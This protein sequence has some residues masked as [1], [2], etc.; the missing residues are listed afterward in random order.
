[1]FLNLTSTLWEFW[2]DGEYYDSNTE[3][4]RSW[5][6]FCNGRW[7]YQLFCYECPDGKMYDTDTLQWVSEWVN[8]KLILND[9]LLSIPNVW[10]ANQF[11]VDGNSQS[12]IELG[13]RQYP[14]KSAKTVFLE[15][16][17]YHSNQDKS[18][19]IYFKEGQD[20][21]VEDGTNYILNITNVTITS[22]SDDSDSSKRA[23]LIPTQI[24]QLVE[25]K[26]RLNLLKSTDLK[27][28]ETIQRRWL[29]WV[30]TNKF[31]Y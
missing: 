6:G 8:P 20:Y 24:P 5:D 26:T 10:R 27:L 23:K 28:N 22:Y 13:T 29:F 11:Y 18:I 2:T 31:K 25:S 15:L 1:M 3:R 17:N 9:N 12:I 4:C 7:G 19:T 16:L 21:Y 14:Y 30:W